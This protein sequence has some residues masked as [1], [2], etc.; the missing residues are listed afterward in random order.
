LFLAADR[1]V[2]NKARLFSLVSLW[3]TNLKNVELE[4]TIGCIAVIVLLLI[5]LVIC[6]RSH[7]KICCRQQQPEFRQTKE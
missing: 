4:M 5:V 3:Q 6:E 1:M 2:H 7:K